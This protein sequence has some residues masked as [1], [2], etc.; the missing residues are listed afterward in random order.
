MLLKRLNMMNWLKK[1]LWHKTKWNRKKNIT[2]Y[3]HSNKYITTQEFNKLTSQ[4]LA[5]RIAQANLANKNDITALVKKKDFE[6]KLEHLK[7][8]YSGWS[9]NNW[10]NK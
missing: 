2:D 1:W 9:E 3:D 5:S 10:S 7:Q 8:K 4:N 6:D